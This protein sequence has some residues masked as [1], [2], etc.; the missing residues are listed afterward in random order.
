MTGTIKRPVSCYDGRTVNL[1]GV[2]HLAA[3]MICSSAPFSIA[4]RIVNL[5]KMVFSWRN[6]GGNSV[7]KLSFGYIRWRDR[8]I[9]SSRGLI[10]FRSLLI[11]PSGRIRATFLRGKGEHLHR[12]RTFSARDTRLAI[13]V[14]RFCRWRMPLFVVSRPGQTGAP[15]LDNASVILHWSDVRLDQALAPAVRRTRLSVACCATSPTTFRLSPGG[16]PAA[17]EGEPSG[18][19]RIYRLY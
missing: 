15:G 8:G 14:G 13:E 1:I 3:A 9:A 11:I 17:T 6:T 5:L 18:I 7:L 2:I 12:G 4:A 16:R 19:N 10:H